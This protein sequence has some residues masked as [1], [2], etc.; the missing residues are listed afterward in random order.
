VCSAVLVVLIFMF[1]AAVQR[2]SGIGFSLVALPM[3]VP[4]VGPLDG[5][6]LI[7]LNSAITSLLM[8]ID[9]YRE[10]AW[11]PLWRLAVPSVLISFP[12]IMF[13]NGAPIVMVNFLVGILLVVCTSALLFKI[14]V[15]KA[16]ELRGEII[17][18]AVSGFMNATAGVAG[19]AIGA[20][21]SSVGWSHR[22]FIATVQPYFIISDTA[23]LA[24][25][26]IFQD[27]GESL[28][29]LTSFASAMFGC[30]IGLLIGKQLYKWVPETVGRWSVIIVSGVGAVSVL[31]NAI[32]EI[33]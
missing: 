27:Q 5:V 15:R 26:Y 20:Y 7:V 19:P 31:I 32:L 12:A 18:G 29:S 23:V 2:V 25:K 22:T 17:I 28:I 14:R 21:V 4:I 16:R 3:L 9:T 10:V 33:V 1:A 11:K 24:A 6:T 8:T 13:L 30:V